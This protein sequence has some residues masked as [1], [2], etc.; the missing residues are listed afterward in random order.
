MIVIVVLGW[1]LVIVLWVGASSIRGERTLN[2]LPVHCLMIV[3]PW[4]LLLI[5]ATSVVVVVVIA[6]VLLLLIVRLS[7]RLLSSESVPSSGSH[8]IHISLN[9]IQVKVYIS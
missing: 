7:E 6:V 2:F 5:V 1:V 9:S 8:S 3:S 4:R